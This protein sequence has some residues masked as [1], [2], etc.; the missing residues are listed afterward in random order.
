MRMLRGL[1]F[2]LFL[3]HSVSPYLNQTFK[4]KLKMQGFLRTSYF[5]LFLLLVSTSYG[6]TVFK[7]EVLGR[8]N[9]KSLKG[10]TILVKSDSLS[11][12][13]SFVSADGKFEIEASGKEDFVFNFQGYRELYIRSNDMPENGVI[14]LDP[15]NWDN[16]R[17]QGGVVYGFNNPV[18]LQAELVSPI[19]VNSDLATLSLGLDLNYQ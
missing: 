19:L 1:F 5:L 13:R 9:L 7:G 11:T 12:M 17:V 10:V 15:L 16:N 8:A 3:N 6:Q 2:L 4:S 18:G 14:Y